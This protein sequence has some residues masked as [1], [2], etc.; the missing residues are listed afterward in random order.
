MTVSPR[1]VPSSSAVGRAIGLVGACGVMA[2]MSFG[3]PQLAAVDASITQDLKRD[4]ALT[5]GADIAQVQTI[6]QVGKPKRYS[7]QMLTGG[8]HVRD[9]GEVHANFTLQAGNSVASTLFGV[10]GDNTHVLYG[11][12]WQGDASGGYPMLVLTEGGRLTFTAETHVDLVM[13]GSFFTRQIWAW[14]DG[15]GT[16]ELAEGSS[17]IVLKMQLSPTHVAPSAWLA[18]IW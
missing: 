13:E 7:E 11:G 9:A 8:V 4:P 17:L 12:H 15:T 6:R 1:F 10:H 5:L 2:L 14:G 18:S 16:I 3:A